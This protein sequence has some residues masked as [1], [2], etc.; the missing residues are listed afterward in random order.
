MQRSDQPIDLS[1]AEDRFG[2]MNSMQ[3]R[4][5]MHDTWW[6]LNQLAGMTERELVEQEIT[7]AAEKLNRLILENNPLLQRAWRHLGHTTNLMILHE[8]AHCSA[9]DFRDEWHF[10]TAG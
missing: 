9:D 2:S 8:Y 3:L 4:R 6:T 1:G 10:D 7:E 5:E